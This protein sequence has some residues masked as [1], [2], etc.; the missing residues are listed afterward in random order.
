VQ[1]QLRVSEGWVRCGRCSEA[2]NALESM[3]DLDAHAADNPAATITNA[4]RAH[5]AAARRPAVAE[6]ATP[7][8]A[9]SGTPTTG[10]VR[11]RS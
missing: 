2:F 11:T 3:V 1:D 7:A 8:A 4:T 6:P 5:R 9:P 10:L